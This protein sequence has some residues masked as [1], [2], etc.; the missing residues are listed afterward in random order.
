MQDS[1][2]SLPWVGIDIN[3]QRQFRPCCKYSQSLGDRLDDY[4]SSDHLAR[5]R[6]DF[7]DN[8]KPP[9]CKRCWD[10]EAAG[11]HSKRQLDQQYV[12]KG[13]LTR[14]SVKILAMT[15]GNTCNLACVTCNSFASSRWA[16]EESRLARQFPSW[17]FGHRYSHN[18]FYRDQDFMQQL[19][20]ASDQ[21]IHLEISGGEPFYASADIHK[22]FLRSLPNP[23]NIKI[24]YITNATV[25]PDEEFWSIWQQFRHIDIQLSLDGT[26]DRFEYLRYPAVWAEVN[27]NI[28]KYQERSHIQI[29][30]SHTVSWL[31]LIYLNDFIAWCRAQQLPDPYLGPVAQPHYLSV[32]CLPPSTKDHVRRLLAGTGPEMDRMLDYMDQE[33]LSHQWPRARQWIQM[34]DSTRSTAVMSVFP[35]L[36]AI[37]DQS[38]HPKFIVSE[39]YG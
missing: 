11:L 1:F 18:K 16:Q 6:A 23:G 36:M 20:D 4:L 24:H 9:G 29:S 22:Q 2:C 15:F 27:H 39:I 25:F 14:D 28:K 30:I 38:I 13:D 32:K 35:E 26:Q 34:L 19:L 31:N 33:D 21:L 8:K 12:L 10:D 37:L 7:L 5:L 17:I 3:A